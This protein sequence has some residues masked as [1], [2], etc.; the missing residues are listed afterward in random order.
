MPFCSKCGRELEPDAKFCPNCGN[1]VSTKAVRVLEKQKTRPE[2]PRNTEKIVI[3]VIVPVVIAVVIA[4]ALA[5]HSSGGS[6][7][8]GRGG[9][10]TAMLAVAATKVDSTHYQLTITHWGGD[11]LNVADLQVQ[12]S[13]NVTPTSLQI[14]PFTLTGGATSGTFSVGMSTTMTGFTYSP[15]VT[16]QVLTVYIVHKPSKE[17]IFS[18]STVA[19]QLS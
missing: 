4:F 1:P 2:K 13:D 16:N 15:D 14:K 7:L 3:A 10:P 11:D 19:V 5:A 17:K 8:G 12:A 6:G 9:S 18:S